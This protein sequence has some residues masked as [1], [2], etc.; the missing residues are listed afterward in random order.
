MISSGKSN[1]RCMCT[2]A[3]VLALGWSVAGCATGLRE[4]PASAATPQL[5]ATL[6]SAD[7][8]LLQ[9]ARA[10]ARIAPHMEQAWPGFWSPDQ[11]FILYRP[12]EAVL[13]ISPATPPAG[14]L[15][16][17]GPGV[18]QELQGRAYLYRGTLPGLEGSFHID[19]PAGGTTATAVALNP[20]G[21]PP[22]LETLFHEAFH[23]FQSRGFAAASSAAGEFVDRSQIA[24]PEFQAMVEVERRMLAEALDVS[25]DDLPEHLR[26]YLAVRLMRIHSVPEDVHAVEQHLERVE[27]SAHLVGL[28][29]GLLASGDG[30][31]QLPEALRPY[32]TRPL[33]SFSGGLPERLIRGRVYGTG[34]A[35]GLSLDR[36]GVEWR[37]RMEEGATFDELLGIAVRFDTASARTL[38]MQ[39]LERFDFGDLLTGAMAAAAGA[40][41][42][43]VEDFHALATAR[44][45]VEF[46]VPIK[47]SRPSM[48]INFSSGAAGFSQLEPNVIALPDPE[49]FTLQV[50][51]G[52]L[53]VRGHPVLQDMRDMAQQRLRITVLLPDAPT[54][55]GGQALPEGE[56]HRERLSIDLDGVQLR[57]EE[58][59][60]VQVNSN[61]WII[62][63]A[64]AR[65][66]TPR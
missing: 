54:N 60:I 5:A 31:E 4:Q 9:T 11:A 33:E 28:E 50:P 19:F 62:Q 66:D 24:A 1:R 20:E 3:L 18:P 17:Q 16:V 23:G 65:A 59:V 15:P 64:T 10:V 21:I 42:R 45:V 2:A 30:R 8:M 43:S 51:Q 53:V 34:A 6:Q 49:V 61:E 25:T 46:T 22:T 38:A 12:G 56:H 36:L 52:S 40:E 41:I 13:L 37:S 7:T 32:L 35:I 27:G 26:Q 48:S 57:L 58:P 44:L 63:A 47:D 55:G 39:A 14:F 29:A